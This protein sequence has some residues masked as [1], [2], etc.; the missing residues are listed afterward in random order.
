MKGILIKNF[1]RGLQRGNTYIEPEEWQRKRGNMIEAEF[2][3]SKG[4]EM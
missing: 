1:G 4:G 3:M 2:N